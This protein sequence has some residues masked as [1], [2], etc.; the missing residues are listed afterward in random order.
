MDF[1]AL[2]HVCYLP[3]VC[4][5]VLYGSCACRA[6]YG[7]HC[8]NAGKSL[9]DTLFNHAVPI[10]PSTDANCCTG[11]LKAGDFYSENDPFEMVQVGK[12]G[13]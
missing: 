12:D 13:I 7:G 1:N 4:S 10:L 5:D 6:R 11:Y 9:G 3:P 2:K 8:L